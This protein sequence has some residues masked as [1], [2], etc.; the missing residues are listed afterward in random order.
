[1]LFIK[2]NRLW[3]HA[4]TELQQYYIKWKKL[5]RKDYLLCGS[6]YMKFLEKA[7]LK[8]YNR[9]VVAENGDENRIGSRTD[10]K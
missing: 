7:K 10:C 3:R 9:L 4:T 6:I 2:Q 5:D 1:M 8:R